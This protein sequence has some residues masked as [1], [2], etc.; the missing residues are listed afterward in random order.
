MNREFRKT[1]EKNT[2]EK[3]NPVL[4]SNFGQLVK[5]IDAALLDSCSESSDS[6][7][8]TLVGHLLKIRDYMQN[9]VFENNLR[10]QM[11]QE[12]NDIISEL[13]SQETQEEPDQDELAQDESKK[14]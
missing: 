8:A 9:V 6:Q 7:A 2:K 12:V 3:I 11:I 14:N 1:L 13:E 5:Y 4:V 10:I